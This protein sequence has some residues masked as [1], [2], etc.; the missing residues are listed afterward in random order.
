VYK[1]YAS[2]FTALHPGGVMALV[3]KDYVSKGKR[4]PLCDDTLKL[5]NRCGFVTIERVRADAGEDQRGERSFQRDHDESSRKNNRSFGAFTRRSPERSKLIGKKFLF[6]QK[7][8]SG[9]KRS[10]PVNR[11]MKSIHLSPA[12]R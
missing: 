4:V 10:K 11:E 5:L 3:V 8:S 7:S 2:V 6:V 1:V 9:R 12:C